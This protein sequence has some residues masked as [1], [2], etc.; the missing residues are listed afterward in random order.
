[1]TGR[2]HLDNTISN[3]FVLNAD[4]SITVKKYVYAHSSLICCT[5][6]GSIYTTGCFEG[7]SWSRDLESDGKT[8]DLSSRIQ[9]G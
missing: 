1:M 4:M 8:I 9:D 2:H 7:R 6:L 5:G 3:S